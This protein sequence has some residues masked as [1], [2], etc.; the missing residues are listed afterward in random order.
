M[1]IIFFIGP[2]IDTYKHKT[3]LHCREEEKME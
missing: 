3:V 2:F 1:F